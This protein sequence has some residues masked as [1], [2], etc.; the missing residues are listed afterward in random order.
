MPRRLLRTDSPYLFGGYMSNLTAE[1]GLGNETLNGNEKDLGI[2]IPGTPNYGLPN[3]SQ[4]HTC[5]G[6]RALDATP[7]YNSPTFLQPQW[8]KPRSSEIY[9]DEK[10][11]SDS[12]STVNENAFNLIN[13]SK[14]VHDISASGNIDHTQNKLKGALNM[15]YMAS[16]AQITSASADKDAQSHSISNSTERTHPLK[17]G[18]HNR[19]SAPI[20]ENRNA[21]DSRFRGIC[22]NESSGV[23]PAYT[24]ETCDTSSELRQ[25]F[26]SSSLPMPTQ[27]NEG[28]SASKGKGVLFD[29]C[30]THFRN[31]P[32]SPTMPTNTDHQTQTPPIHDITV[33]QN[34]PITMDSTL[35]YQNQTTCRQNRC[36]NRRRQQSERGSDTDR[37]RTDSTTSSTQGVSTLYIDIGDCTYACQ[38]CNAAFWYGERLKGTSRWQPIKYNKCCGGGQVRFQKEVDPPMYL[39]QLFKDKHFLDNIRAYNQMFSMTS[40]GAEIDDS[41]NDGRGPY[42]F[43]IS[44]EIHH[45]IGTI[46]PTNINEPKFMQLYVYDTQN[47][48]AHR[49]K[50]FGGKDG[51]QL[52]AEIV[53]SLIQILDDNNELVR[54]FRTAREKFSEG[55][56]TEFKIQLYNIVGTREYQLPSTGTLGAIV[57]ESGANS[58]TD[59]DVIIEYKDR[60]PQ[61]IN[62]L[63]SSYMS[64]QYPLLF[65]YGQLGYNTKMTLTGVNANRKRN[66][67][68][69]NMYYKYQLH[70]SLF[71]G[72]WL[73][74]PFGSSV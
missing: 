73:H 59:Y 61:R 34:D 35:P 74:C 53:Q 51:S 7:S 52:K 19:A 16:S 37:T 15:S 20:Y 26:T 38:Y 17:Y 14:K 71:S 31:K 12:V 45:W 62:K 46:C 44:G 54:T 18:W 49:M 24:I 60:D 30:D 2:N 68:S 1:N 67:L 10:H 43:K 32:L 27:L 9:Q 58:Q 33:Q 57:F 29:P 39:K 13:A 63:H 3:I 48:V 69:M 23:T 5:S 56:V 11:P 65:V 55:N 6:K 72:L 42:V 40:F 47:E 22:I 36:R 28:F 41:V 4:N 66:K 50:P 8:K 21:T 64:L 25:Q 70:E